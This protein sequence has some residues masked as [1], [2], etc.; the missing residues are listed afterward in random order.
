MQKIVRRE[1]GEM[2][3]VAENISL[4]SSAAVDVAVSTTSQERGADRVLT[5]ALYPHC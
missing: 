1:G 2:I 4:E 5:N 3:K